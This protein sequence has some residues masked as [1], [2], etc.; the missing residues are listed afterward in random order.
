MKRCPICNRTYDDSSLS[1]CPEDGAALLDITRVLPVRDSSENSDDLISLEA[2]NTPSMHWSAIA[3]MAVFGE[4][5]VPREEPTP[6]LAPPRSPLQLGA[7]QSGFEERSDAPSTHITFPT[8]DDGVS[9]SSDQESRVE[10]APGMMLLGRYRIVRHLGVG[11]FSNIYLAFDEIFREEVAVKVP[12]IQEESH[13]LAQTFKS[14]LKAWKFLS[15]KDPGKVVRLINAEHISTGNINA[16]CIFMEFMTGG[17]LAEMVQDK[18]N[19]FPRNPEQ[20]AQLMRLFLQACR[21]LRFL[22]IHK[23]LHRDIKPSNMLLDANYSTCK[24]SDFEL[25]DQRH[26]GAEGPRILAGTPVYMAPECFDNEF[27][28]ASDI[29]ALGVT[30]FQLLTGSL[31]FQVESFADRRRPSPPELTKINPLVTPELQ[32]IVLRCLEINPTH[33]PQS[34]DDLIADLAYIGISDEE[35]NAAPVNLARLLLTHLNDEDI[36]YLTRNLSEEQGFHSSRKDTSQ[37]QSDLIQEYCYTASPQE[38]LADNCTSRQ[39]V[40]IATSLGLKST[41]GKSRE[42]VIDDILAAIGFLLGPRKIPGLESTRSFLESQLMALAHATTS[43]ECSGMAHSGLAAMERTVDWLVRFYGQLIH[44]S[45]F[46]TFLSRLANGK[47]WNRLTFGEKVKALR[48]LC[49]R[50]PELPLPDR[51]Q[52]VFEWPIFPL[53]LFDR[54]D[55]L[56]TKRNRLAHQTERGSFYDSQRAARQVLSTTVEVLSEVAG[57]DY[58]P[59]ILQV[60]SRQ[61][62]IYGRRF[63]LGR[64]D[65]GHLERVFTPLPLS[66]GQLYLIYPLTN[67]VRINPLIFPYE[68]P[69]LDDKAAAADKAS[70]A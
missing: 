9:S 21:A 55:D 37:W 56:V 34:V 45:G 52:K 40:D 17:N 53:K 23:T 51:V 2:D 63:Y 6:T 70:G 57:S 16:L 62:D 39:I 61:D 35:S 8:L 32:Q 47:P 24:L 31:P 5:R 14:Q 11:G 65:R 60:I 49:S 54:L 15:D 25:L 7:P 30:L 59:H 3:T 26:G 48:S 20:L 13:P 18:W 27:S 43:D 42:E 28:E 12:N 46:A 50:P 64:D 67:P 58:I 69:R 44:G 36:A 22:H 1:F 41:A 19:G 33:R 66:V 29:F 10:I 68:A 38:V 4:E